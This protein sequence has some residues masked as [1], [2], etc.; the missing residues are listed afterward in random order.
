MHVDPFARI[1]FPLPDKSLA[2]SPSH[3]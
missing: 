1:V 3:H 2:Q